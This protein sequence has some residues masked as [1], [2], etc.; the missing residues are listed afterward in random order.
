MVISIF[1]FALVGDP[2][3]WLKIV[4]RIVLIPVIA[5]IAYEFLRFSAAHQQ[6]PIMKMLIAPGL[7]LQG[8]TTREPD[9]SMLEVSIAALKKL[10]AEE[11]LA[12]Q[13][14]PVESGEALT[15]SGSA[16]R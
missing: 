15:A 1:V 16:S 14:K 12:T 5:G 13:V 6:N 2:P 9:L 11:Q 8:M 4:S 10:L 7:A 3:L